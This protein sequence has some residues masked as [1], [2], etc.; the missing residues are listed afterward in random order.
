MTIKNFNKN[1][2]ENEKQTFLKVYDNCVDN[3]Y[4]FVYFKIGNKEE[5][6][7]L[8]SAVFL[9]GW[10]Y[11]QENKIINFKALKSLFYKIA[12]HLIIDYYRKTNLRNNLSL[13]EAEKLGGFDEK[14]DLAKQAE[15]TSDLVVIESKLPELKDEYREV[16]IL[17]FVNELSIKEIAEILEKPKGTVRVLIY[18]AINAL[19]DLIKKDNIESV[20]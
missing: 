15:I 18:R 8:T 20:E 4:R 14:Q 5:A 10:N 12:R 13:T 7:D 17:R 16:I 3:I 19:K 9:K 1:K 11:L 2:A 6:E